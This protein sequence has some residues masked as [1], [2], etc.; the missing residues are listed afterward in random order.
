[1]KGIIPLDKSAGFSRRPAGFYADGILMPASA[2]TVKGQIPRTGFTLVELLVSVA[3]FAVL[4]L[5]AFS[6]FYAGFFGDRNIS[7]SIKV[8][9]SAARVMDCINADLRN[10]V[11]YSKGAAKFEGDPSSMCFFSIADNFRE[12]VLQRD[13]AAVS[14]KLEGD[15]LM[16]LCLLNAA[17]LNGEGDADSGFE[18]LASGVKEVVFRYGRIDAAGVNVEWLPDWQ[19]LPVLPAAVSIH[20][21]LGE[22]YRA[23]FE[24]TV[25]LPLAQ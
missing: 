9:Q 6:A 10:S 18:E 4:I 1:M 21:V 8:Y 19:D 16:R 5:S 24:R 23:E 22:R 3:I 17:A 13:Y 15:R 12:S 2:K 20:L 11:A 14:Y 25:Y 7:E